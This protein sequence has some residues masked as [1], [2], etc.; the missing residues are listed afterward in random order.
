[1]LEA[2]Y[3]VFETKKEKLSTD[4]IKKLLSWMHQYSLE[5]KNYNSRDLLNCIIIVK[6]GATSISKKVS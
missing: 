2:I 6:G 4:D 5:K 1:M 3:V